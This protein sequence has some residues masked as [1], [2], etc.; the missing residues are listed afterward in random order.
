MLESLNCLQVSL[1]FNKLL[2]LKLD[3]LIPI[4]FQQDPFISELVCQ[5]NLKFGRTESV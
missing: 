1:A 4:W 5:L 3:K 2:A